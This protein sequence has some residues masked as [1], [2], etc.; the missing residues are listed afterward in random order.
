MI[1]I[2]LTSV[3]KNSNSTVGRAELND[4]TNAGF[5]V[6]SFEIYVGGKNGQ[7]LI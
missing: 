2:N 5:T 1:V 7:R 6:E 4:S 3:R